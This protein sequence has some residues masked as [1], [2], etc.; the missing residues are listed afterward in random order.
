[1][2]YILECHLLALALFALSFLEAAALD[3]SFEQRAWMLVTI[4]VL[5]ICIDHYIIFLIVIALKDP[6][7]C[8][9]SHSG[10]CSANSL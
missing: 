10:R 2:L 8:Q 5:I 3:E 4:K 6:V 7:Y 9:R 1:M